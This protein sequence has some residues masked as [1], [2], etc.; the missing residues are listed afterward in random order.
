MIF[1]DYDAEAAPALIDVVHNGKK[2]PAVVA[3][4]K[5]SLMF[6]L[7]RETGKPIYPVEER[8]VPQSDIPWRGDV[9]NAAVSVEASA[10]GT[11]GHQGPTKSSPASLSTRSIAAS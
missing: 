1:G 5:I 4:S 7:D 11:P 3:I 2:I 10:T 8:P 6:F 9:E